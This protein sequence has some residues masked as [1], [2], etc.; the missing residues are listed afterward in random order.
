MAQDADKLGTLVWAK[1]PSRDVGSWWPA[2]A[3]DPWNLP[4]GVTITAQQVMP[5]CPSQVLYYLHSF[6][7]GSTTT[8]QYGRGSR[9]YPKLGF[10]M[11]ADVPC[12]AVPQQLVYKS[13]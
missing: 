12:K 11:Q 1:D 13:I 4:P 7:Y 10:K 3:L 6:E 5:I 9:G 8:V 2:E